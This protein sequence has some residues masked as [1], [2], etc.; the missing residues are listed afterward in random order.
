[1]KRNTLILLGIL[2]L[3]VAVVFSS[4]RNPENPARR[5]QEGKSL[6]V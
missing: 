4:C 1:M 2:I 3:L 5:R 6:S